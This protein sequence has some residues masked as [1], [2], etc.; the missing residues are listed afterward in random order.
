M[1]DLSGAT[2]SS[3]G[4]TAGQ[5]SITF[6]TVT[7]LHDDSSSAAAA[8]AA[9]LASAMAAQFEN[10]IGTNHGDRL[11]GNDAA[12]ALT[13]LLGNDTLLGGAGDDT[14]AGGAGNDIMDGGTGRDLASYANMF[15][16]GVNVSLLLQNTVQA[17]GGGGS[18]L[19]RGIE[20]LEGGVNSDMLTG[21]ALGNFLSGLD[22][23]DTLSGG[24]GDDTLS[25]GWGVVD[26]LLG[27]D[28]LD[29]ASYA[30]AT[31]PV[32]A[33]LASPA[34]NTGEAVRDIYDSIEGLLGSLGNDRLGG[35]AQANLL[36]GNDG[37]DSLY[38]G[39]GVDKLEGGVGDDQLF[40]EVDG[41]LLDGGDGNDALDGGEGN[42]TIQGGAGNDTLN[43]GAGADH[44]TGGTG[45]DTYSVD[46]V[47]DVVDEASG[48][49]TDTVSASISFALSAGVE[50]LVLAGGADLSGTGNEEA[51]RL[52]GN[53]GANLL[54]AGGGA[55]FLYGG[56]GSDTLVG[57]LGADRLYGEAGADII[58][59]ASAAERGDLI[60]GFVSGEDAIEVSASG[61][62]GG[63]SG[64]ALS[65]DQFTS[66]STGRASSAA[67]IGQFV[68]ETDT[69]RL[70]WDVD[71]AGGQ[72]GAVLGTLSGT[73]ALTVADIHL[74][75]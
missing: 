68:Y 21:D 74:V 46:N 71:G 26:S 36:I 23:S 54:S 11:T 13:G 6:G 24:G 9:G 44:L 49:G 18:D 55:D 4:G 10:A 47:L 52:T 67:G 48:S 35:D 65:A 60:Y 15:L 41:D 7:T 58:R 12:N 42:D 56:A 43:G 45:N 37:H 27:G 31:A 70:W 72:A 50:Q 73:P 2:A 19:L 34:S 38:G 14:L 32:R 1:I 62:G 53:A 17:T 8:I 30:G 59:Y 28:G 33:E 20:G 64:G 25:G 16:G 40:G 57:G 5:R 29:I 22:G 69:G 51:N 61:F 63:L 75:G 39:A 66:N 3:V